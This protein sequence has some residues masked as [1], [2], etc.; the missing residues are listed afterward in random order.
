[1]YLKKL[2]MYGFKSFA[3]RTYI[4]FDRGIT[5]IV[6]P[7]GSGKSNVADAV[8][9]V[10]G[11]QSAKSLRGSRMED[12]IF[13]GTQVRKPL[14][15]AE[16]SLTLDNSD[17][18]LPVEFSEVTITR[19][20]FRSGES[21]YYINRS[22][23]RLKDI[24]EL[25]MDTGIGKEGYSIISQGRIEEILNAQPENRR[26]IFEEAAGIVKY[27][28]RKEEAIR[29]LDKTIDNITRVEDIL[30]EISQ[31]LIPLEKQSQVAKEYL[32]LRDKLKIY[33]LNQFILK[34]DRLAESINQLKEQTAL[35]EQDVMN[36]RLAMNQEERTYEISKVEMN[37]L[38]DEIQGCRDLCHELRQKMEK[39]KG[40]A[41][42]LEEKIQQ[43][44]KEKQ[45]IEA[46]ITQEEDQINQKQ[47]EKA[48]VLEVLEANQMKLSSV[49]EASSKLSDQI[50]KLQNQ[51]STNQSEIE[52]RRIQS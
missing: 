3:D 42:I 35:L 43:V 16:V 7:N 37:R 39:Y 30:N 31:Q 50:K 41:G 34:Y 19:R 44:I 25:F 46:E 26:E 21:E 15:F 5:A 10:L 40:E 20:V 17:G 49:L 29:K 9:W 23:C 45:R 28:S 33:R 13:N 47:K 32:S 48:E 11:E 4:E 22:S 12:V 27:K 38:I 2:E 51:L 8:R 18:Y 36:H 24:V 1:L 6:G 14:G 52:K